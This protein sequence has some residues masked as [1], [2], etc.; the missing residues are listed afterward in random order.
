MALALWLAVF[1]VT[2]REPAATPGGGGNG[3]GEVALGSALDE[4]GQVLASVSAAPSV[5]AIAPGALRLEG[6]VVDGDGNGIAGATVTL[7]HQRTAATEGDGTFA[8][9]EVAGGTYLVTAEHG[10]AYGEDRNVSLDE[11]SDPV[12]IELARGPA[13]AVRVV[14]MSGAPIAGAHV[15]S[16]SRD[17][18]T[19]AEG[20]ISLRAVSINEENLWIQADGFADERV[21]IATGDDPKVTVER[22]VQM[23]T[24]AA[25]AGTVVDENGHVVADARVTLEATRDSLRVRSPRSE[26]DG[27]WHIANLAA[28]HYKIS[29]TS[30]DRIG[31]GE[32]EVD[33]DGQHARAGVVVRVAQGA[34]VIGTVVDG[35]G[36]PVALAE[37]TG[38]GKS[39]KTGDDGAFELRGLAAGEAELVAH[40]DDAGSLTVKKTL[41]AHEHAHVQLTVLPS[42]IAGIVVDG[43]GAPLEGIRITASSPDPNGI[44]FQ[45]TDEHGRF[46]LGGIPPGLYKVSARHPDE[47]GPSGEVSAD[48]RTGT[49]D[50]KLVLPAQATVI[51]RVVIAG[52]PVTYFGVS[53]ASD[54]ENAR[55]E[56]PQP[57]RDAGGAFKLKHVAAGSWALAIVGPDFRVRVIEHVTVREGVVTDLGD[58]V[59]ERGLR[60]EGKVVDARGT[61]V[62]GALVRLGDG[63]ERPGGE[64]LRLALAGTYATRS[65]AGGQYHFDGVEPT[66]SA[67]KL[68]ATHPTAGASTVVEVAPGQTTVDLVLAATGALEGTFG[69]DLQGRWRYVRVYQGQEYDGPDFGIR[70]EH[71]GEFRIDD[72]LPGDYT[73]QAGHRGV[74]VAVT[75]TAG[76]TAHV[77]LHEA[78]PSPPEQQQAP[79][80]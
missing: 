1:A 11:T 78:P 14:A 80:E 29:A 8:F 28:G 27:T 6:R 33:T 45:V 71:G 51:G 57:V 67:R 15:H 17:G 41:G 23:Q 66:D 74:P 42:T 13:L 9:D 79:S 22:V 30:D 16:T 20:R 37:V 76:A 4:T 68:I 55:F 39:A 25:L 60:I 52:A 24:A 64:P 21:Q 75:I 18:D 36:R 50:A 5:P 73:V 3:G 12:T 48:V 40:T 61:P 72:L 65:D 38:G 2:R 69:D 77:V 31:D 32:I 54:A 7:A 10:D 26:D 19:D 70:V 53:L 62:A 46:T 49:R 44:A 56:S 34:S 43:Q 35:N 59:V 63:V 47:T 58:V